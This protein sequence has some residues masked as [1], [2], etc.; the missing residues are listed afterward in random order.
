MNYPHIIVDNFFTYPDKIREFGLAQ[1]FYTDPEGRWPGVRTDYLHETNPEFCHKLLNKVFSLTQNIHKEPPEYLCSLHFQKVDASYKGGWV[2]TDG[3]DTIAA[4]IIYL[5]PDADVNEGTSLYQVKDPITHID[6]FHL[7]KKAETFTNSD[8]IDSHEKFRIEAN[9]QYKETIFVGNSYNRLFMFD[10]S[11]YHG[12]KD[13]VS[14][15]NDPRLT[16]IGFINTLNA[17][18]LPK[19]RSD[20][21][22]L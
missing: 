9:A 10:G 3:V 8:L 21:I 22:S 4:F 15:T 14:P 2:H 7:D 20:L 6:S 11:T 12:A 19:R 16:L 13:F 18:H 5:S 1:S 17:R